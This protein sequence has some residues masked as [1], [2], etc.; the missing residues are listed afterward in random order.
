M[1]S[2]FLFEIA[3]LLLSLNFVRLYGFAISD[4]FYMGALVL[5]FL[6]TRSVQRQ[7]LICWWQNRFLWPAGL[8]LVGAS[9]SIINALNWK[10]ALV[11]TFQQIF[12]I[13]L[14]ISLTWIMVRR[15]KAKAIIIAFVLS[16]L[17]TS[18]IAIVDYLT[19]SKFGPILSGTPDVHFWGR[20]AGT[21]GHPNKFG[22]FLVLTTLVSVGYLLNIKK[23]RKT[24]I[25][26][27][28]VWCLLVSVQVFGIFLS[29]SMTAFLGLLLGVVVY[30]FRNILFTFTKMKI[31]KRILQPIIVVFVV[32][33]ILM[34]F[35]SLSNPT[36]WN[37]ATNGI[38]QAWDR[39]TTNTA[40]SRLVVFQLAG[41][42]ILQNPLVGVG[43]DQIS[44][45]GSGLVQS[46]LGFG[47]HN[48]FLQTWYIGGVF[49]FIGLVVIYLLVG[50]SALNILRKKT[51][52]P[53]LIRGLAI[54]VLSILLMD[55]F[56]DAIYQHEKWLVIGL[57]V[58]H[59]WIRSKII[60][61]RGAV[62]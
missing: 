8:I 35:L 15:G 7:N 45:S 36:F 18:M 41:E 49:A 54:A 22:C 42:S 3:T 58:G 27:R 56:Q 55:Q 13:T 51:S 33:M 53:P 21:L 6:E 44:T 31:S 1:P 28:T 4:W 48:V 32:G 60:L 26:Y 29:N 10:I 46:L 19:G 11:Q 59:V 57:F 38:L 37:N 17:F 43:Y 5:A 34:L 47:V 25:I 50:G 23:Q 2:T 62:N 9:I 14:F 40:E 16:G 39:V 24:T 52:Y 30:I 12:V 61:K 20:Y